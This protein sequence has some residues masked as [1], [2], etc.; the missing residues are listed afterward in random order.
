MNK[1]VFITKQNDQ[2][3]YFFN[4]ADGQCKFWFCKYALHFKY[5]GEL[6]TFLWSKNTLR[7]LS[8]TGYACEFLFQPYAPRGVTRIKQIIL[9]TG[10]I[11]KDKTILNSTGQ[12]P[13][14]KRE[15]FWIQN[16]KR[17]NIKNPKTYRRN[18][19]K[20]NKNKKPREKRKYKA[21]SSQTES[22]M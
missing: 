15:I 14:S 13:L 12:K 2:V 6:K 22:Q 20:R 10:H 3:Y 4:I 5:N 1:H 19:T 18:K 8:K 9:R 21:K 7:E 11:T 16:K 17:P